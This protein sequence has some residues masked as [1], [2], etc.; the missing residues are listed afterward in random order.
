M[1]PFLQSLNSIRSLQVG[2]NRC[3]VGI[4]PCLVISNVLGAVNLNR[5]RIS[6]AVLVLTNVGD[7]ARNLTGSRRTGSTLIIVVRSL[8][9]VQFKAR[10]LF[11]ICIVCILRLCIQ[12]TDRGVPFD[13]NDALVFLICRFGA[14][15]T[16]KGD[17]TIILTIAHVN[18]SFAIG[19]AKRRNYIGFHSIFSAAVKLTMP[20]FNTI[21]RTSGSLCGF[22]LR[23]LVA[24]RLQRNSRIKVLTHKRLDLFFLQ[25]LSQ[26]L[27][28]RIN[29][30]NLFRVIRVAPSVLAGKGIG[31]GALAGGGNIVVLVL[32]AGFLQIVNL[33]I[34]IVTI[35]LRAD[36]RIQVFQIRLK[37]DGI[38]P[39]GF[40]LS[41]S[42]RRT[43]STGV[44]DG[45]R[46]GTG[47]SHVRRI[48]GVAC[49]RD[50]LLRHSDL[51]AL[52]TQLAL[53]QTGLSASGRH[54][55]DGFFTMPCGLQEVQRHPVAFIVFQ[56]LLNAFRQT[57]GLRII[58]DNLGIIP[59]LIAVL[60]LT[61]ESNATR[62]LTLGINKRSLRQ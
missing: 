54:G 58:V 41:L 24:L 32:M 2:P 23:P 39:P 20:F 46:G 16:C 44:S 8:Q 40:P 21:F 4:E 34:R 3:M 6:R 13:D 29:G 12:I 52:G 35:Q 31:T 33:E 60:S 50:F 62:H 11:N 37:V 28:R 14:N 19:M 17:G 10:V 9:L 30:N 56:M 1:H 47:G 57:F 59:Q 18:I 7:S 61:C 42:L 51:F 48:V 25:K 43:H 45:A 38:R 26:F 53:G 49:S 55:R 5:F 27:C 15:S 36:L 22:P